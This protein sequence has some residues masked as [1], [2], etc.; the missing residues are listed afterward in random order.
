MDFFSPLIWAHLFSVFGPF[1][2]EDQVVVS[3]SVHG[4]DRL[5]RVVTWL[6]VDERKTT[7]FVRLSITPYL[8][9][10]V[11]NYPKKWRSSQSQPTKCIPRWI[12]EIRP[13][14]SKSCCKSSCVAADEMLETRMAGTSSEYPGPD[15]P[16]TRLGGTYFSVNCC[17]LC[18]GESG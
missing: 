5:L 4:V 12:L 7:W 10:Y 17:R 14:F 1:N 9:V 15:R 2:R 8:K 16:G 6:I 18:A 11:K 3:I 13:N